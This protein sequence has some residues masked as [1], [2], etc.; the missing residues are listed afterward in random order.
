MQPRRQKPMRTVRQ[1][2][3]WPLILIVAVGVGTVVGGLAGAV[4]ALLLK[5][6][7]YE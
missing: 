7:G 4:A 6:G 2:S 1:P 5:L 3:R